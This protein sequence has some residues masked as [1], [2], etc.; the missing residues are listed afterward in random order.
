M[1]LGLMLSHLVRHEGIRMNEISV[2]IANGYLK[3]VYYEALAEKAKLEKLPFSFEK[4]LVEDAVIA[5]TVKRFKGL[6]SQVVFLWGLEGL[7]PDV[8]REILYVGLTRAKGRLVCV[9]AK[10]DTDSLFSIDRHT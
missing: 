6:E 8:D 10:V 3:H 7:E 9:G 5:D 4:A 1:F 2:L